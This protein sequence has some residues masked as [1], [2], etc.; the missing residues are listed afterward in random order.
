MQKRIP[1]VTYILI[2]INAAVF[3]LETLMGGSENL[4]V[5]LSFGALY[6]PLVTEYGQLWRLFTAMF[7]HFGIQH[8]GSNMIS[9]WAIGPYAE[10]FFGKA[11]YLLLYLVS[12]ICGNLLTV[13]VELHT[14]SYALSAGASGAICGLLSVFLIFALMPQTRRAFPLPRVLAAIALVLLPGLTDQSISMT[15]HLGGLIGGFLLSAVMTLLMRH[16]IRRQR[17]F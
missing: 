12:G 15:D 9:L 3:F 13:A 10:T 2:G 8:L 1:V 5:A 17:G 6:T 11:R 14:G 16:R 4:Q 7:L